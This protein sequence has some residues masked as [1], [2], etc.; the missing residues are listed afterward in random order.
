MKKSLR[1]RLQEGH[2]KVLQHWRYP[3]LLVFFLP[4]KLRAAFSH[5][6]G[7]YLVKV[8]TLRREGA[9]KVAL[10]PIYDE[11]HQASYVGGNGL[12]CDSLLRHFKLKPPCSRWVKVT[13]CR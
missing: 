8:Y 7:M 13:K 2:L 4:A 3:S 11:P 5:G 9:I 10:V 6:D 12:L 1:V